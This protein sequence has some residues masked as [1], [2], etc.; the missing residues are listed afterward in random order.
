MITS[1]TLPNDFE[2]NNINNNS[3]GFHIS[4]TVNYCLQSVNCNSPLTYS[5]ITLGMLFSTYF[6]LRVHK[7]Y[8]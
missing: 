1:F 6:I 3:C 2:L 4:F 8:I 5:N 7:L